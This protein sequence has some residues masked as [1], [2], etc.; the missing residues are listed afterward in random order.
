LWCHTHWGFPAMGQ[1]HNNASGDYDLELLSS[2]CDRCC[3]LDNDKI[4]RLQFNGKDLGSRVVYNYFTSIVL[5]EYIF[6]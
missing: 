1:R 3:E 5:I 6:E 4:D 2:D